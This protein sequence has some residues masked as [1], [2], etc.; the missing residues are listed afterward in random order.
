MSTIAT[1]TNTTPFIYPATTLLDRSPTTG[2][3]YALVKATTANQYDVYRSVD[4][5]TNWSLL[6]SLTRT[7]IQEIGSI[8][9]SNTNQLYW[10]YRTNESSQDRIY[11]RQLDLGTAAWTGEVLTGSPANGG[12]AGAV[13]T[14][15]DLHVV[16]TA[17]GTY[18]AIGVGTVVGGL[19]GLTLYGVTINANGY[20][21]N[22]SIFTGTRQWLPVAGTG[23]ISPSLDIEHTGDAKTAATPHLWC[24]FGRGELQIVKLSWTGAGWSGPTTSTTLQSGLASHDSIAGRWDG[25]R[26][27][28]VVANP[29]S[30]STVLLVERDRA[31]STTTARTSPAHPT[32]VV[33]NTTVSYNQVSGDARV[34]AVGTS[35]SVL[36]YVDF[37]RATGLWSSWTSVLASAVLG[38]NADN[39]GVRRSSYGNARYDVYSAISGAPNTLT[40]TQQ[41]LSYAPNIPTWTGP[42]NGAAADV[43]APLPLTWAFTDPDTA[44]SQTAYAVSRQIGAG[45]LA[46]WRASDST[47]QAT[48]Q[49][50]TS[51]TNGLILPAAWGAG[52]DANHTYKVKVWDVSDT[53]SGYSAG[54]VVVASVTVTPTITAPTVAQVL[55]SPTVNAVWT[56]AEQTAYRVRTMQTI[57]ADAFG[58][59]VANG[60]GSPDYPS[61]ATYTALTTGGAAASDYSV[62]AGTGRHTHTNVNVRRETKLASVVANDCDIVVGPITIPAAA[63]GAP[64]DFGL[65]SCY[66]DANNFLEARLFFTTSN[67]VTANLR[68]LLAG[69]ETLTGFVTVAGVTGAGPVMLRYQNYGGA[70]KMKVWSPSAAEPDA[71]TVTFTATL[72]TLA[73]IAISTGLEAGNTNTLNYTIQVDNLA[74]TIGQQTDSGWVTA[75]DTTYTVPYTFLDNTPWTL[76][77]ATR[78]LEGLASTEQYVSFTIDYVEPPTPTLSFTPDTAAGVIHI[79][80]TN[81]VVVT[82]QPA[83]ASQDV[84]RRELTTGQTALNSNT[85]FETNAAGWT[86]A[87]GTAARSTAQFHAGAASLLITPTGGIADSYA[88]TAKTAVVAAAYTGGAWVRA[89]TGNKPVRIRLLWYTAGDV[90]ISASSVQG[91]PAATAWQYW[92]VTDTPPPTAAKVSLAVGV[93]TTPAA[94]DT[95]YVDEATL[96]VA[97][98]NTGIRVAAGVASGALVDDFR[99]V[100]GQPYEYRVMATGTNGTVVYSPWTA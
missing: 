59:T 99:A 30:T 66:V 51:T 20:A 23:R 62:S 26:H 31:N 52:S 79:Q 71:W 85:G 83:L 74:M 12:V 9:I 14:G 76:G 100:S 63:A 42:T 50:N 41:T 61:S 17:V 86:A 15:M 25:T 98:T 94:G 53:A 16:I 19:R 36:Y 22:N 88:E 6:V 11:F 40:H 97:D 18:I 96:T 45:A 70:L 3:L 49:K 65:R 60:W 80:I 68:Q 43:N 87:G 46:Y 29:A 13:H 55:T 93:T 10:C 95:V 8:F 37:I 84:W 92:S 73:G 82:G 24:V 57:A 56:V 81:P 75:A 7:A 64:V 38:A 28:S 77:L 35:T 4:N 90:F 78:N 1:T 54:L 91:I 47:W 44:D 5:G 34:Y 39:Y 33:R 58:R 72:N 48:E 2:Y 67:T 27:V 32:G 21:Y 89:T 69:V